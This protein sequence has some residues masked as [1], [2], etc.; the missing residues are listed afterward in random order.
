MLDDIQ[1]QHGGAFPKVADPSASAAHQNTVPHWL[2][3]ILLSQSTEATSQAIEAAL[4]TLNGDTSTPGTVL[5]ELDQIRQSGATAANQTTGNA[6]LASIDT[7]MDAQATAARQDTGNASLASVDAKMDS[8]ATAANQTT[9]ISRLVEIRDY[10]DTVETQIASMLANNATYEGNRNTDQD[11]TNTRLTEVRDFLDTVETQLASMLANLAT[12]EGNRNTDQDLANTRLTEVRDYLD[13]VETQLATM[14]ANLGTYEGNRNTDQDATNTKLD[15]HTALLGAKITNSQQ[16][17]GG[18]GV[19]GW[20]SQLALDSE[21]FRSEQLTS[22]GEVRT[23]QK[24][25]ILSFSGRK[26]LSDIRFT[27]PVTNGGTVAQANNGEY[28]IACAATVNGTALLETRSRGS[29]V[30]GLPAIAELSI[31]IPVAPTGNK[32]YKWG[33]YDDSNGWRFGSD[34]SGTYVAYRS[35]GGAETKIYQADWNLDKLDGSGKSGATLSLSNGTI[36]FVEFLWF[37]YGPV[38]WGVMLPGEDGH[39]HRILIHRHQTQ[40]QLNAASPFLPLRMEVVNGAAGGVAEMYVG[41]G[42]FSTLGKYSPPKRTRSHERLAV[43]LTNTANE[44]HLFTIRHKTGTLFD[45]TYMPMQAV[46]MLVSADML[47]ILRFNATLTGGTWTAPTGVDAAETV[48]EVSNDV[49][50]TLG[51]GDRMVCMLHAIQGRSD[52]GNRMFDNIYIPPGCSV[53]VMVRSISPGNGQSCSAIA[54]WFE[55][56]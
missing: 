16:K 26:G 44:Q 53:S 38:E 56:W 41:G 8:Q 30:C 32:D 5:Y 42:S 2:Q 20:L 3:Q 4:A 54:R 50:V 17:V 13:T 33:Y 27:Y 43:S 12:Y 36:F 40:G 34:S 21:Y 11:L 10:L 28:K 24:D 9:T 46:E 31:R 49:A 22:M 45:S 19:I 14:I 7:K 35:N 37:G 51:T 1:V 18:S 48:A 52:N 25:T 6:S 15:Q 55:E 23:A 29:Y 47:L 39:L